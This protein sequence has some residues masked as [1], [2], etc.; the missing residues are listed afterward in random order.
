VL[1]REVEN[2]WKPLRKSGNY[3]AWVEDSLDFR[4]QRQCGHGNPGRRW[5]ETEKREKGD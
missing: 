3:I 4:D 5:C 2:V 1:Q